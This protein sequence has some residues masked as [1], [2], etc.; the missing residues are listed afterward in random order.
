[1][2]LSE[3]PLLKLQELLVELR[4]IDAKL[5]EL[6]VREVELREALRLV[7]EGKA[8]SIY[9]VFGN[10]VIVEMDP[11]KAAEMIREEIE[12]AKLT[13]ERL[14]KRREEIL[15]EIRSLEKELKLM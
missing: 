9:R 1:M 8:R 12:L 2:Q 13:R 6:E 4:S 5:R 7:E 11:G 3:T 15:K 14:L 10:R